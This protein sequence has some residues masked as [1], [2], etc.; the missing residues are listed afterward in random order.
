MFQRYAIENKAAK[1]EE[2][3][4]EIKRLYKKFGMW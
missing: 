3:S 4:A 1:S 2:D